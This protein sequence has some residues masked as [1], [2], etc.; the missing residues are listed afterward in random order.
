MPLLIS[1]I[2][3]IISSFLGLHYATSANLFVVVRVSCPSSSPHD[4]PPSSDRSTQ[5]Y[6]WEDVS[7][8][9]GDPNITALPYHHEIPRLTSLSLPD[10]VGAPT[11]TTREERLLLRPKEATT[12][13]LMVLQFQRTAATSTTTMVH[14]WAET[15]MLVCKP[16]GALLL[17]FLFPP[18]QLSQDTLPRFPPQL[19]A[20]HVQPIPI[21][22]TTLQS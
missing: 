8:D 12:P 15:S 16:S 11:L 14:P 21:I 18:V 3:M 1:T 5:H 17:A 10:T 13:N 20:T 19:R 4:R 7:K 6:T 2:V 22:T 9:A